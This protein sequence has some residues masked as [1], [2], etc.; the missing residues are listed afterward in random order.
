MPATTIFLITLAAVLALGFVFFKYFYGNKKPDRTTY[1]LGGLRFLTIF[2]LML[3]LINP[4]ITQRV[5]ETEKPDLFLAVDKSSSIDHME[6]GD[7]VTG[8]VREIAAN[9]DLNERFDIQIYG[10]GN[11]LEPQGND[12][13]DFNKPQTNIAKSLRELEKL[14]RNK[15]SAIV[16]ITDGN[17][18]V[19]ENYQYYKAGERTGIYPVIAGDTTAHIDLAITNINVNKYAFLNNDFPIEVQINYTGNEAVG[20]RFE[21]RS[22]NAVLYTRT[23]NFS[24]ENSSEIITTTLAANRLGA[25]VYEAVIVPLDSERNIINNSRKFGVEVIDERTSVLLLSSVAHPDLGAI[26][27]SIEQNEQREVT[28][29]YIS[30]YS[31]KFLIFN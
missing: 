1:I 14:N 3:L 25:G 31:S 15:Q 20:S 8:L 29:E 13:Y 5:L 16:L 28:I 9:E 24:N 4:G 26:K 10:F 12:Q 18:T 19:G 6:E 2:I 27:K 22:G 23:V 30:E 17:Q 11:D 21:I 7:N